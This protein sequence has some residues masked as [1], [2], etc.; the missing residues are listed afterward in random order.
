LTWV[1]RQLRFGDDARL[2]QV[3]A[4]DD[5]STDDLSSTKGRGGMTHN[6]ALYLAFVLTT[7][8]VFAATLAWTSWYSRKK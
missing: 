4:S 8:A 7:G 1:K 2:I 6:E 3:K 5:G